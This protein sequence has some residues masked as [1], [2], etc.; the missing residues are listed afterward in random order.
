MTLTIHPD[1]VPIDLLAARPGTRY[2]IGMLP[3]DDHDRPVKGKDMEEGE[4]AVQTAGM[5]CRNIKFQRW[6]NTNGFSFG[7]SEHECA[8]GIKAFCNVDS[9]A[10]LKDNRQARELFRQLKDRFENESF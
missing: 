5:L 7:N 8:D 3:V 6:M 4:K 2:M 9:R 1:E 10:E